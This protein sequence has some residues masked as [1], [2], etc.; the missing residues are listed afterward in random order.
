MNIDSNMVKEIRERTGAGIMA[1]KQ[2]LQ[3][4]AGNFEKAVEILRKDGQAR[5]A[6]RQ[7]RQAREGLIRLAVAPDGK[8]AALVEVNCETD[9]VA[10]TE[11]FSALADWVLNEVMARGEA[12]AASAPVLD[13]IRETAAKTGEKIALSRVLV[14]EKD[15]FIGGYLHFNSR[16]AAL[17]ELNA[18]AP[19]VAREVVMEVA[20]SNPEYLSEAEVPPAVKAQELE[21]A[22]AAFAD[23][24][25]AVRV[26]AAE[27]KWR[28]RLSELCLLDFPY[29]EEKINIAQY[30][31]R[32]GG[33]NLKVKGYVRWALGEVVASPETEPA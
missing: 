12:A 27:G 26:K 6:K 7:G 19:E 29:R 10:R 23:K 2:A 8:R 1:C 25:P 32:A 33:E 30:V 20:V 14:W 9:F 24:A 4:A 15:G 3:K 17:V 22:A 28:K 16:V 31:R 11:G 5:V 21:I 18:P 13:R